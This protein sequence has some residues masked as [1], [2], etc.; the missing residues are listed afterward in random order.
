MLGIGAAWNEDESRGGPGTA[1]LFVL[2]RPDAR[3]FG[4]KR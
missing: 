4:W 3:G 1:A 2:N